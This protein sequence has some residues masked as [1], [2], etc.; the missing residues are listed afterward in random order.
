MIGEMI[1]DE[2]KRSNNPRLAYK[3]HN[4]ELAHKNKIYNQ[5]TLVQLAVD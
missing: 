1:V 5:E 4:C 3:T 2:A